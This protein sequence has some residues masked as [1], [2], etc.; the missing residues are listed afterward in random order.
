MCQRVMNVQVEVMAE[1]VAGWGVA[2][3]NATPKQIPLFDSF[4]CV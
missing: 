4:A 3:E 2:A 1:G